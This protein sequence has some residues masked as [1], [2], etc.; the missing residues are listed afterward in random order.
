MPPGWEE[1]SLLQALS[2]WS[3]DEVTTTRAFEPASPPNPRP[4][5]VLFTPCSSTLSLAAATIEGQRPDGKPFAVDTNAI[6][7]VR[8]IPCAFKP[9]APPKDW[10]SYDDEHRAEFLTTHCQVVLATEM[11]M[12]FM[13][14][15]GVGS[16]KIR[17]PSGEIVEV[18]LCYQGHKRGHPR[19]SAWCP[20]AKSDSSV[21]LKHCK[22]CVT[23]ARP[24]ANSNRLVC[25]RA[26]I[27]KPK[28]SGPGLGEPSD[29]EQRKPVIRR[30]KGKTVLQSRKKA[31][32]KRIQM[33]GWPRLWSERSIPLTS[34]R[35]APSC[36]APA[37]KK[38]SHPGYR[39]TF[40]ALTSRQPRMYCKE[41]VHNKSLQ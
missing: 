29:L 27:W 5:Q 1:T 11:H 25:L 28:P 34:T 3:S 7:P 37:R 40:P 19:F 18:F 10:A 2:G 38:A 12:E 39:S 31:N 14:S 17:H 4:E 22:Q 30:H 23:K 8:C 6:A 21:K 33:S 24:L 35:L 20:A 13:M 26:F 36:V 9:G 32:P 16:V 15:G 41:N